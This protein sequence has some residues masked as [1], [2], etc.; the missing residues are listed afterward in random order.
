MPVS[1]LHTVLPTP[2]SYTPYYA[3]TYVHPCIHPA[4]AKSKDYIPVE[5]F[6]TLA[7]LWRCDELRYHNSFENL[8]Q[9]LS[10]ALYAHYE[11][12]VGDKSDS[13][14]SRWAYAAKDASNHIFVAILTYIRLQPF[15]VAVLTCVLCPYC[16]SPTYTHPF[17]MLCPYLW[18]G[19]P[20]GIN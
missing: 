14:V 7:A 19:L 20:V 15:F 9:D 10:S 8:P 1:V 4:R 5:R 17:R 18:Q 12:S 2:V 13:G 3:H 11:S 6:L 16:I